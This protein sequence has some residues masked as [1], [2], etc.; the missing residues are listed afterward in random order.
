MVQSVIDGFSVQPRD[1]EAPF[2]TLSGGNQQKVLMGK[3]LSLVP[4]VLVLD[5]PT[6]GVDPGARETVF[7]AI[8]DAAGLGVCVLFFST[9]PEQLVRI[10]NRVVVLRR[11]TVGMELAGESLSLETVTQWCYE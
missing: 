8:I 3:W 10:C 2:S 1:P 4:R 5:D 11:G 7:K 6:Y 9:E